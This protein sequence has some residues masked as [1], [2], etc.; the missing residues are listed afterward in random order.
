MPATK[1][2][3]PAPLAKLKAKGGAKAFEAHKADET[4]YGMGGELPGGINGGV[5]ELCDARIGAY[6]T[7]DRK[8]EPFIYLAAVV[9]SPT[10]HDGCEIRGMR[11]NLTLPLMDDPAGWGKAKTQDE[12]IANALNELRKCGLDTSALTLDDLP[13][14]LEGLKE[15]APHIRFH[16]YASKPRSDEDKKLDKQGKFKPRIYHN[17]DGLATS[18]TDNA[19]PGAGTTDNT[20]EPGAE[21]SDG[22]AGTSSG[23]DYVALAEAADSGDDAAKIKL[24]DALKAMGMSDADVDGL[25]DWKS[26]ADLLAADAGGGEATEAAAVEPWTPKVGEFYPFKAP[27]AKKKVECK[28]THVFKETMNLQDTTDPKK[29]Y[30]GVKWTSEPATIG[31]EPL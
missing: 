16:T 5:A 24:A 21:A 26:A 29:S 28:V 1:G 6:K 13:A 7:G 23:D 2:S 22:D 27:G 19:E 14:A 12:N 4:D 9:K 3:A 25:P 20:A 10:E 8:D 15:A 17:W 30:K 31:G 11:T 18:F